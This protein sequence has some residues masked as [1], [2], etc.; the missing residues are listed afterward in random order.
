MWDIDMEKARIFQGLCAGKGT[1]TNQRFEMTPRAREGE[2]EMRKHLQHT[3]SW[4]LSGP[5]EIHVAYTED[6]IP[7]KAQGHAQL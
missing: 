5:D 1:R 2:M 3:A 7:T 6:T 4:A